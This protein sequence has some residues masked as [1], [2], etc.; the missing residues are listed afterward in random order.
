M[1]RWF[2][3]CSISSWLSFGKLHFS[4]DLSISYKFSNWLA[5][6]CSYY[7]FISWMLEVK[8]P[9]SF[10]IL[11]SWDRSFF[12]NQSCQR[13]VN[14]I[15][16]SKQQSFVFVHPFNSMPIFLL[17]WFQL[18]SYFLSSRFLI[19]IFCSFPI[20][21]KETYHSLIFNLCIWYNH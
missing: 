3:M 13:F 12:I 14:F 19:L 6:S 10:L 11:C 17:H 15:S 16:L 4:R 20:L 1:Y 5:W 2:F 18:R 9:F 21:L 8:A 7:S